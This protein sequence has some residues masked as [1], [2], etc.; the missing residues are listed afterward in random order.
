MDENVCEQCGT[1]N[2]PGVQF[3]VS[4]QSYLPWYDTQETDL[5]AQGLP[6]GGT[7]GNAAPA[8]PSEQ[9]FTITPVAP[10]PVVIADA[11]PVPEPVTAGGVTRP[12]PVAEPPAP[13]D[14]PPVRAVP[15][16]ARVA[17][18]PEPS[19]RVSL[20]P[21]AAEV[22]PG[23]DEV[24]IAVHIYNISPIVDAYRVWTPDPPGWLTTSSTEVRLLPNGNELTALTLR[25][26]VGTLV[27]A[28]R[29]R[30]LIRVQSVAHPEVIVEEFLD[31]TVPAIRTPLVLLLE[32]SIVRVKNDEAGRLRVSIDNSDGNQ[33]RRV[34]LSGRDAE[35]VVRFF[36]SPGV[37]EVPAGGTAGAGVRVEG[38]RPDPG[39]QATR[40]LTV[41]AADGQSEVE[42]AAT[43]IQAS[44]A[45]VPM[46]LRVEPS[47]VRVRD[48][49]AGQLDITID[50]RRGTRTRRVFLGG[51]DPERI[52]RFSF[53][54]PSIDVL[55]GEVG[56]ARLKIEAPPPP[57]GQ[58]S[59]RAVT[60]LASSDGLADLEAAATFVQATSAA[61]A[62]VPVLL[63]LDPSVVRVRDTKVGQLEVIL[64]N[65]AGNRVRRVFLTGR[66]PERLVRFTFSPP[67]LDVL[68]GD[69]GRARIRLEAP[70]PE[71]GQ[72]ATRQ[73]TVVAAD[74]GKEIEIGG[75]FIQLTSPKPVETPVALKL[76]P[77]LLRV[78]DTPTGQ[79]QVIVDNRQGIRARRVT[80]V[81]SDPERALGFSFWPPVVEVGQGQIARSNG[82]VE[83]YPPEPGREVTRQFSVAASDGAKEVE[84]DG[85]FIQATSALP[86]DEPMTVRLDPSVVRVRNSSSGSCIVHADNRGGSRPRRVQFAGHDPERVVRFAFDPPVLDLAPGQIGAARVEISAPRPDGG[87]QLNRP[88]TI[89]AS[90]GAREAE[91]TGSF[92]QE[93]SD[94]RPLWRVL[95][96]VLGALLM[97]GG[98][99]LVW[100]VG[101]SFGIP[102]EFGPQVAPNI[103]GLEWSLPALDVASET[104]APGVVLI[105]LPNSLDPLVSA[106]AAIIALA[107]VALFGLV[108]SSGRLTRLAA[109]VA[110]VGLAVFVVAVQLQPDTGQVGTGVFVIFAG[111][112]IAFVGGLFAKPRRG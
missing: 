39:E 31:L 56:R 68:P 16:V 27:P 60:V 67:S 12:E 74:G 101:A 29:S 100:N 53:S 20:D 79:F 45:E 35:G 97:V 111:C 40:Q 43:F 34:T 41:I 23:G 30:L 73:V 72:E 51:R 59:T 50:N 14:V 75:T 85:T 76:E 91:T 70:L 26:P 7:A 49:A 65:R 2:D 99:F 104:A 42:A 98:S 92:V 36:F 9:P 17:R 6:P 93:S 54:P 80:L 5:A 105:D 83:G 57:A 25:I 55:A 10:N 89:V 38:P 84:T 112:A 108:G 62:D 46:A 37:I 47:L 33:A 48:G 32:P 3:C 15:V 8:P 44:A 64:D 86:P 87:E 63:R 77:S 24:S 11:P 19:V 1:R 71:P 28:G 22:V 95:L 110:A 96:T 4:C 66:D 106:G 13:T 107:A 58:E 81:G 109:L 102:A 103:T 94:R 18:E 88:F 61:A 21:L 82:R 52:V 69:I 78:R 90:D